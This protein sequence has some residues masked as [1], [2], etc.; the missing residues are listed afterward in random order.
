MATLKTTS[1]ENI[2]QDLGKIIYNIDPVETP[3]INEIGKAKAT[4]T[5][6]EILTDELAAPNGDNAAEEGADAA[7][8]NGVGPKKVG[9]WT[10]IFTKTAKVSGTLEKVNNAGVPSPISYQISKT[11][12][13]IR[14]DM[15]VA[16][17]GN[18]GS[19]A[20]GARKFAGAGAWTSSNAD[21]GAGGSTP[22]FASNSLVGDVVAGDL[23][24][25]TEDLF[26]EMAHKIFQEG[27]DPTIVF[28]PGKLKQAISKFSGNATKYQ[29]ATKAK[30]VYA[31]VDYYVSDFGTHQIIPHRFMPT[32]QVFF[33]DPKFWA[34]ATVR[35]EKHELG[36]TGDSI[37]YQV[38]NEATLESRNEKASGVIY[39]L[40]AN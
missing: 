38:L 23:R 35:T 31:G 3:F 13:E 18:R 9:N 24:P 7:E 19:V 14:R 26:N 1:V 4:N 40:T 33:C 27:G 22:G 32:T 29:D 25:I 34:M 37:Q 10:Q 20:S 28:A 2:E 17:I 30:T 39:D 21:H 5:Y 8:A 15:E 36:R 11:L 12:K 6:H 16:A